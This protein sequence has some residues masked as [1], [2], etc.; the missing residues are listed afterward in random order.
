MSGV[1]F[2][3]HKPSRIGYKF[4]HLSNRIFEKQTSQDESPGQIEKIKS[5]QVGQAKKIAES[6]RI[7]SNSWN[8]P[9]NNPYCFPIVSKQLTVTNFPSFL[10]PTPTSIFFS[11]LFSSQA[12]EKT[13]KFLLQK[14]IQQKRVIIII[15]C[16]RLLMG[17][18]WELNFTGFS[19]SFVLFHDKRFTDKL[20]SSWKIPF[21]LCIMN[22][23]NFLFLS[24]FLDVEKAFSQKEKEQKRVNEKQ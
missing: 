9:P 19:H 7:Y 13:E 14:K 10:P 5:T 3:F 24:T 18:Q 2:L 6:I 17:K 20:L 1:E 22:E 21:S 16:Y 12:Q 15:T 11:L 23:N 4:S 8:T